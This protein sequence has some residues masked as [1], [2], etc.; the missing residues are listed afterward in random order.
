MKSVNTFDLK[1]DPLFKKKK[2]SLLRKSKPQSRRR[3]F[4]I[5]D[6]GLVSR[7]YKELSQLKK[8][9]KQTNFKK[10]NWAKTLKW[11]RRVLKDVLSHEGITD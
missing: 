8:R 2:K 6:T 4:S 9:Y 5:S 10:N 1:R 7:I 11:L 3:W